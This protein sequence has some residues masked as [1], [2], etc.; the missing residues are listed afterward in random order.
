MCREGGGGSIDVLGPQRDNLLTA[1]EIDTISALPYKA[2]AAIMWTWIMLL[3]SKVMEDQAISPSK[4][5]DITA[6][7]IKARNAIEKII[8]YL[9][10]QLPFAYVHLVTLLVNLNNIINALKCGVIMAGQ[11]QEK[12]YVY[13]GSQ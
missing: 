1:A 13:A 7:I 2:Q 3:A 5:R 4:Q 10:T 6:E 11:I 9:Q 8:T 12:N